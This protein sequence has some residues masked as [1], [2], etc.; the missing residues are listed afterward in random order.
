MVI[1]LLHEKFGSVD[2]ALIETQDGTTLSDALANISGVGVHTNF[3]VHDLFYLRGFDSLANGLVLSDGA[4]E[5]EATF[6]QLYN[7]A[8]VETLKGPGAFLYGG[9]I[10][11]GL[12]LTAAPSFLLHLLR[13]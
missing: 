11:I 9:N 1:A 13:F 7:V 4:P 12:V 5:P 6:Y 8:R 2:E 3:G 10:R